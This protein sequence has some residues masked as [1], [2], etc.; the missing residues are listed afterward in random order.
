[1]GWLVA[2]CALLACSCPASNSAEWPAL[3]HLEREGALVSAAALDLQSDRMLQERHAS[4]RL[5]PASLTKL[6]TA[7]ALLER[8]P[9]DHTL[10]TRLFA[11]GPVVGGEL[12]GDLVLQGAGDPSLDDHVLWSLAAQVRG[13]GITTVH[14]RLIVSPA[15]FGHVDCETQD[16]CAARERSVNAYGA[17]LA[18]IGVDFGTWCID[19]RP[20]SVGAAAEVQG[21]GMRLPLATDGT[22]RTSPAGAA[23]RVSI[24]R[25]TSA[26]GEDRLLLSGTIASGESQHFYRAMSDPARGVGLLL[27]EAL[28]ELGVTTSEVVVADGAAPQGLTPI[29]DVEGLTLHE[30]V[31]RM[32]RFSNNYIADV[33]T[34]DLASDGAAHPPTELSSATSVLAAFLARIPGITASLPE[35]PVLRSGSGLTTENRLS[36]RDLVLLLAHEYRD[37]RRFPAFYGALVVPRDAPF[38]FLRSGSDAWLDRVALKTGT[39]QEPYSVS[40]IAGYLR[41]RDGAWVA[42]AA[43]VNGGP[44][45][46]HV[47]HAT[48]LEAMRADLTSLMETSG[49]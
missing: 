33:L 12:R 11:S 23:S 25:V 39:L 40:G 20:T 49:W 15:P 1:M 26:S 35:A 44:A 42:F 37:T 34:L 38:D 10:R 29:A 43:I 7:A 36:A 46:P 45:H 3:G 6:A 48:A 2:G 28:R 31:R 8:W 21:C 13:A 5:T 4:V 18:S 47:P 30:Q 14:G 41:R 17:P 22:I 24:E 27:A 16:R 32:L 9:A 19:V